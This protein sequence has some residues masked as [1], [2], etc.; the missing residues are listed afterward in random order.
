MLKQRFSIRQVVEMTGL[1][2]SEIRFY[3]KAFGE[4]LQFTRMAGPDRDFT[5]DQIDILKRIKELTHKR[6][7]GIEEVRRELKQ[8]SRSVPSLRGPGLPPAKTPDL[9]RVIAVTSGKGGVGKT[10][11][12]VNLAVA[13]AQRGKRVA[14]F[15]ADL[16]LANVHIL[17][18][19][20]PRFNLMH[21]IQDGFSLSDALVEGPLGIKLVSGGQG[22]RELANLTDEQRRNVLRQMDKLER[23]VDIL[24]VDTGAGISENVLRFATFADEV[25]VVTTSNVAAT[26][27]AYSIIK[28]L[29]EMDPQGKIGL[30]CNMAKSMYH[31]KNVFNRLDT[32]ARKYLDYALGDLGYIVEDEYVLTAN[33]ARKPLLLAFPYAPSA[34]CILQVA[35]TVLN[36]KVF[37]NADKQSSFQDIM[38]ALKRTLVGAAA[39]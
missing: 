22:V 39:L 24:L 26:V 9:A 12:T 8:I 32:A 30:L 6:G 17:M 28:I 5:P 38:G 2:E 29:R 13:L 3:E 25:I 15:D 33:Q 16:G 14:I 37:K 19:V 20:R 10:T 1:E 4:F 7:F 34:R 18:G 27:D 31:A 21:V 23:E 35:D 11:V 36:A